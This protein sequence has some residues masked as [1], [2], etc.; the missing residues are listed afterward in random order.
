MSWTPCGLCL[1]TYE[2]YLN[3]L[4]Y[5]A[6]GSKLLQMKRSILVYMSSLYSSPPHKWIYQK[7]G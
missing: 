3:I 5:K 6:S 7:Q 1:V 4:L 2:R